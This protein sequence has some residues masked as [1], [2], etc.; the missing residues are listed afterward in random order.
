VKFQ[1]NIYKPGRRA[2]VRIPRDPTPTRL[3]LFIFLGAIVLI[4]LGFAYLYSARI[5]TLKQ[6]MRAD[7]KQIM[8]LRQFLQE[9][10]TDQGEKGGVKD[11]LLQVRQ[12]R[13]LWKDKLI[14][15]SRLVPD[16]IQLT[17]MNVETVEETP[18]PKHPR[19]KEKHTVLTMKGEILTTPDQESLDRIA[20]LIMKLNESAVFN[21]DFG[22]LALVYTQRVKTRDHEIM[23]FELSG[24][25]RSKSKEG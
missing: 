6:T 19:H 17:R 8:M 3:P 14:E 22:P 4:L 5:G 10:R 24:R 15:L 11:L 2:K 18:D 12:Q 1:I 13:V 25:L 7:K 23:E 21:N 16:S 20:R 9:S